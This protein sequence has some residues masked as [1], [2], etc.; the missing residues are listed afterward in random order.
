MIKIWTHTKL[1]YNRS[2]IWAIKHCT[3][4][5]PKLDITPKTT[6]GMDQGI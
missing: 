4:D 2:T 3:N 5:R 6:F 1:N